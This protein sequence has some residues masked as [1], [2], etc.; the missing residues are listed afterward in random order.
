[1]ARSDEPVVGSLDLIVYVGMK[2]QDPHEIGTVHVP[3]T[4]R[5]V[6]GKTTLQST[7]DEVLS[8][9]GASMQ[10][11]FREPEGAVA[12][13]AQVALRSMEDEDGAFVEV[14]LDPRMRE[15]L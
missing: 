1:M 10:E 9:V 13:A 4:L 7:V 11:V 14:P 8:Y 6:S 15:G 2:G 5:H 12:R 3:I